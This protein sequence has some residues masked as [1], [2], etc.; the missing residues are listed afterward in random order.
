MTHPQIADAVNTAVNNLETS[1]A[2]IAAADDSSTAPAAFTTAI[3]T[4]DTAI[5]DTTGLFG[6]QGTINRTVD[7][8]GF[9]PATP[10]SRALPATTLGSVSR[11]RCRRDS[12]PRP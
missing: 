6:P 10:T 2:T 5:L 3:T 7:R 4:F 1:A 8:L 9:L 11:N 12:R